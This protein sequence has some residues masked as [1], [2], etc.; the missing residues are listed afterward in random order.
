MLEESKKKNV[1]RELHLVGPSLMNNS[2]RPLLETLFH[3]RA[4]SLMLWSVLEFFSLLDLPQ[5]ASL[6]SRESLELVE[7]CSSLTSSTWNTAT[8]SL[9]TTKRSVS[10]F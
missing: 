8:S 2:L 1:Y 6:S 10:L 5:D 4:V 3:F 9:D 7:S